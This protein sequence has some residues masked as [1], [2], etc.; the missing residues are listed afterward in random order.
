MYPRLIR[1]DGVP[2]GSTMRFRL[3]YDGELKAAGNNSSRAAEKWGLR[4][5]FCPQLA[6][7][8]ATHPVMRGIGLTTKTDRRRAVRPAVVDVDVTSGHQKN[9]EAILGPIELG[10]HRFIPLVRRSLALVCDL[11][12]L[13]LRN[14]APGSIVK[15][16]GDLDNRIKTLFD[17][18]RMPTLDELKVGQPDVDPFY[19]LLENDD[20]ISGFAVHTDRL[21]TDPSRSERRV[22]LVS[23]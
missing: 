17:G 3:V 22:L 18:L 6:S 4:K 9:R 16:G 20:H 7:L 1:A 15:S 2:A 21:L 8:A 13:F 19:C 11:D 14:D 10:N 23:I 12:I 5:A